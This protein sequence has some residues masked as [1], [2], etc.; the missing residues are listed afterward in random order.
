M[1]FEMLDARGID[2]DRIDDRDIAFDLENPEPWLKYDVVLERS[3]NL[4]APCMRCA[5]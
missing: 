1:L 2:Y 5:F 3:I 4:P